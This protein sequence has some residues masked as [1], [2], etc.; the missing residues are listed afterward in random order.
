MKRLFRKQIEFRYRPTGLHFFF[1]KCPFCRG[2]TAS[3]PSASSTKAK[4]EVSLVSASVLAGILCLWFA[5]SIL[6][7]SDWA[8]TGIY[9]VEITSSSTVFCC[10]EAH[11]PPCFFTQMTQIDFGRCAKHSWSKQKVEIT[12]LL[13]TELP[14]GPSHLK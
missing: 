14:F 10:T 13:L 8:T 4:A 6:P 9:L 11:S 3:I 2:L 5:N 12:M 7:N 1:S